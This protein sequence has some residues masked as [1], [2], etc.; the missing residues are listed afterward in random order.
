LGDGTKVN[1]TSPTLIGNSIWKQVSV[2]F[3]EN[4]Y[5]TLAILENNN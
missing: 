2:G 5:H 3:G 4:G 1:K